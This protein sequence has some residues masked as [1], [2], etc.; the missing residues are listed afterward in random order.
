MSSA[1]E[2][3]STLNCIYFAMVV[4]GLIFAVGSLVLGG[5]GGG[6]GDA[7]NGDGGGDGGDGD[8]GLNIFSP[9][10]LATF[11]TVFGATGLICTLALNVDNRLS[12]LIGAV[13]AAAVSLLVAAVYGRLLVVFQGSTDIRQADMVGRE[14]LVITSIP[15]QGLGEVQFEMSGERISRPAQSADSAP[16]ARGST[17]RVEQVAGA[18]VLIVRLHP[19]G[20][21]STA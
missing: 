16:I 1:F 17:V 8:G 12:L 21:S 15:A 2:N 3:L 11:M 7:G 10:T 20:G 18:G 13:V 4:A 5:L 9:V 6:D 19:G 14:A